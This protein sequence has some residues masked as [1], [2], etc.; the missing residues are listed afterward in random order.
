MDA[1]K[2]KSFTIAF[3]NAF[4][5]DQSVLRITGHI[6]QIQHLEFIDRFTIEAGGGIAA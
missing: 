1:A 4:D 3:R 6:Q 2:R 5:I